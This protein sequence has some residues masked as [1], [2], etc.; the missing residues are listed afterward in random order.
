MQDYKRLKV[1]QKAHVFT[2]DVYHVS[3]LFPKDELFGLTNQL[4]RASSS[5]AA[6]IAEGCGRSS[7]KEFAQFLNIGLGSV[8]EAAYFTMLAKDLGYME[9]AKFD[10]LSNDANEIKG[11][12]IALINTVR[13]KNREVE[14]THNS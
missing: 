7:N 6:N 2:L 9:D 13:K 10:R 3:K 11:M 14:T 8:N 5:I 1:W 12:L 4:R